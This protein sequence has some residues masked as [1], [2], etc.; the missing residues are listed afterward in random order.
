MENEDLEISQ[1]FAEF[2]NVEDK[3]V[4]TAPI[5][6]V[7]SAASV[8]VAAPV[9]ADAAPVVAE[10]A[11]VV[12]Q[13]ADAP[14]IEPAVPAVADEPV[15]PV[16][17]AEPAPV[18]TS[19]YDTIRAELDALKAAQ[20]AQPA[21]A[22]APAVPLYSADEVAEVT[23]YQTDWPDVAKGEALLRRAEYRDL[24]G[25][26]FQ[27]VEQRYAPALDYMQSR[28]GHDQYSDITALVP[29]YDSV[30]D[31]AIAWVNTQPAWLKSTLQKVT[32]EGSPEEVAGLIAMYKKETAYVAPVAAAAQVVKAAPALPPAAIKA[33]V[34]L[35]AVKSGR[36]EIGT[37]E[38]EDFDTAFKTY[39]AEEEKRLAHK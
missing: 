17:A 11:P 12:A 5:V 9:I 6:P 4:A 39:A 34:K 10:V 31:A 22:P 1:A 35:A 26:I 16:V 19:Q 25:Y 14:V 13:A 27:Q 24:V 23:K 18:D 3:S 32:S 28:S 36:S 29:D 7:E 38:E 21:P 20:A 37:A 30:R 15:E 2:A 33:A 8:A